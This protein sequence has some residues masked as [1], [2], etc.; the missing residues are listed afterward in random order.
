[1][2]DGPD[3][4]TSHASSA[5]VI[6]AD[7]ERFRRGELAG[8][9]LVAFAGHTASCE[10]CRSRVE[11]S[12]DSARAEAMFES[13][14]GLNDRHVSEDDLHAYAD[15]RIGSARRAEIEAHVVSCASCRHEVRD[16]QRFVRETYPPR[17]T[18]GRSWYAGLAAAALVVAVALPWAL[19][20]V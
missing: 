5:H 2:S 19:R 6:D 14:A 13:A 10:S 20:E 15:G 7:I 16:L 11:Q 9:P 12:V 3:R 18:I 17:R 1:M 4:V 8:A